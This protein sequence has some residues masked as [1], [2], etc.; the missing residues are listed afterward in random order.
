MINGSIFDKLGY[1]TAFF[2]FNVTTGKCKITRLAFIIVLLDSFGVVER[3][4]ELPSEKKD[5]GFSSGFAIQK[6]HSLR[7]A[8]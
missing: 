5:I 8:T 6:L 1:F 2:Y 4:R 7:Q 3:A